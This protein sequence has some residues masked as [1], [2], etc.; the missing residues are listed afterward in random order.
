MDIEFDPAKRSW[1][2]EG[3]GLDMADA[4]RIFNGPYV[5]AED[6]RLRYGEQRNI[7]VGYLDDRMVV[8]VWTQ[9]D[10]SIRVISFRKANE[11]EREKFAARLARP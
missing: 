4:V 1:T 3:R 10:N 2:I 6:T 9:R 8:L 11:R 5:T 7:T